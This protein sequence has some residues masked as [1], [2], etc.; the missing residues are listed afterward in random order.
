MPTLL[1]V[2]M[3]SFNHSADTEGR[4]KRVVGAWKNNDSVPASDKEGPIWRIANDQNR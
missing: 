1:K 4:I 3:L 2:R